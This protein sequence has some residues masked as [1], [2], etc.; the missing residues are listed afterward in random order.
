MIF[1]TQGVAQYRCGL[2]PEALKSLQRS[3]EL[4]GGKEPA[5]LAFLA[6]AQ[7]RLGQHD[8]VRD[9]LARLRSVMKERPQGAENLGFLREAEALI[10]GLHELPED[11]FSRGPSGRVP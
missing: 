6:M 1:N 8:E 4:S 5:D 11:V 3:N 10:L 2:L 7:Y 9:T